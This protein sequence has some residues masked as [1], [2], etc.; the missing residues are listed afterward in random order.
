MSRTH[1]YK[2][3]KGY[4][5][6]YQGREVKWEVPTS[7]DEAVSSGQFENVDTILRYATAQLNIKKGHA[8]QAAT[9]EQVK[10]ADGKPT[11]KLANPNMTLAQM[12]QLA[13]A[14]VAKASE[15]TKS[16]GGSQKDKAKAHETTKAKAKAM[17]ETADPVKLAALLELGLISKEEHDTR[18]AAAAP[19]KPARQ[20]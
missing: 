13:A 7:I 14:T 11:G 3:A 1:T 9:V 6:E 8:I 12:E 4:A 17:A 5:P 19:A 2:C 15:R 18:L 20:R 16:G 10:D